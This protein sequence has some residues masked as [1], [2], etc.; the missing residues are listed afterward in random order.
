MGGGGSILSVPILVYVFGVRPELAT[1]YSLFVVG[2]SSIAGTFKYLEE[3]LVSIKALLLFGIPALI[4][5]YFNRT[6]L[7]PRIPSDLVEIG[8]FMLTKDMLIM[9]VFSV[10]MILAARIMI[11]ERDNDEGQEV[12][13][14]FIRTLWIVLLASCIG[15]VTSFIGAGGGFLIIP[16][17]IKVFRFPV[18]TAI[19]TSLSVV[20][21]NSLTGF[22]GDISAN[23]PIDWIF[24]MKFTGLSVI[25]IFIGIYLSHS[26]S[27]AK[28]KPAFGWFVLSMGTFIIIKELVITS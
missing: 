15:L 25:G 14:D 12:N 8:D 20:M 19:G 10:L 7:L 16:A 27:G 4:S 28:L 3:K 22:A 1:S 21:I 18:K 17:L 13:L 2:V 11:K 5:V 6:Y 23:V 24:L 26:I 9:L